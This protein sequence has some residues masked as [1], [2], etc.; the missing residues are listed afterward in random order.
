MDQTRNAS[1]WPAGWDLERLMNSQAT[2][3]LNNLTGDHAAAIRAGLIADLGEPAFQE[4]MNEV[5]RRKQSDAAAVTGAAP[6]EPPFM[7]TMR[8][9]EARGQPKWDSWG[10]VVY[11]SPEILD[12]A[13]WAACKQR[14]AQILDESIGP[15]RGYPGL[16]EVME[17]MQNDWIENFDETSDGSCASIARIAARD[18]KLNDGEPRLWP[19]SPTPGMHH[20]LCLY[21]TPASLHSILHC[22]LPSAAP[23]REQRK[24]MPFVVAVSLHAAASDERGNRGVEE[25]EEDPPWRGYFNVAV[26]SLLMSLFPIV[27]DEMMEPIRIGSHIRGEDVW[28]DHTRFGVFK[29][30][31]GFGTWDGRVRRLGT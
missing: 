19:S 10:F 27:A 22:P 21:I 26:E 15:C 23:S 14:F 6:S 31:L 16:E 18:G 12:D 7:E 9:H 24:E 20:G 28:V 25:E 8:L 17:R 29:P 1:Y 11:R 2:G 3:G 13:Y 4:I 5:D 30:G